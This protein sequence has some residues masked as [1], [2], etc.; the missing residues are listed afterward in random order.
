M[1]YR[2]ADERIVDVSAT[3]VTD[4]ALYERHVET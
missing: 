4:E 2:I 3:T 1:L